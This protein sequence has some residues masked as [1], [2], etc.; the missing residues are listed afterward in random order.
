MYVSFENGTSEKWGVWGFPTT[1]LSPTANWR[2]L[3]TLAQSTKRYCPLSQFVTRRVVEDLHASRVRGLE[4]R[5]NRDSSMQGWFDE[6][7]IQ[8]SS[9]PNVSNLPE[10]AWDR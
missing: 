10:K 3:I 9:S 7:F 1:T 5:T 8:P 2:E 4:R 6:L